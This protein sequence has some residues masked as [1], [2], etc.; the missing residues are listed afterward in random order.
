MHNSN[1]FHTRLKS[2]LNLNRFRVMR[3]AC[4]CRTPSQQSDPMK[5]RCEYRRHPSISDER[6]S[7][8]LRRD[9]HVL[10]LLHLAHASR[11]SES[12]PLSRVSGPEMGRKVEEEEATRSR[13]PPSPVSTFP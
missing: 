7:G 12:N 5:F 3:V 2:P 1:L 8:T 13:R 6:P 11:H 9:A 10:R 4:I